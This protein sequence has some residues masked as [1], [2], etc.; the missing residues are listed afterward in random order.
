MNA[1]VTKLTRGLSA[2]LLLLAVVLASAM[3]TAAATVN[4]TLQAKTGS[5]IMPDGAIVPVWGLVEQDNPVFAPIP[6]LTANEGDT[7]IITLQNNLSGPLADEV[8][9][10]INGQPTLDASG[11]TPTAMVPTF[12]PADAYGRQRVHSFTYPA[13]LADSAIYAW[14]PL[15]PGTWLIQSGTHPGVQVPMGLYAILV[16]NS[17]T[18]G[19]AYANVA[20]AFDQEAVVLFS[21]LDPA[22]NGAVADGSYGTEAYPTAMAVG[23]EPHYFLINGQPWSPTKGPLLTVEAGQRVLLRMANT[24]IE[25]REPVLLNVVSMLQLAEDGNPAAL[26]EYMPKRHSIDLVAGKTVD[27]VFIAPANHNTL[28]LHD[29]MLGLKNGGMLDFIAVV[30]PAATPVNLVVNVTGAGHV[31]ST[32]IPGGIDC[33]AGS[34]SA[35]YAPNTAVTLHATGDTV[36]TALTG[37]SVTDT[38]TSTP[39]G[40][41]STLSDCVVTLDVDKTVDA[42]FTTNT[43]LKLITPSGGEQVPIDSAYTVTWTAPATAITFDLAYS[44]GPGLPF[45]KMGD[46]VGGHSFFWTLPYPLHQS[47]AAR[48]AII[49]YDASGTEL[50][51][52]TSGPFTLV[53]PFVLTAPAVGDVLTSKALFDITWTSRTTELPITRGGLFYRPSPTTSWQPIAVLDTTALFAANPA[54]TWTVA[55]V[56]ASISTAEVALVLYDNN[57]AALLIDTSGAFTIDPALAVF[58]YLTPTLIVDAPVAGPEPLLLLIPNGGEVLPATGLTVIW[59]SNLPA[60]SY[61]LELSI[62]QGANW[63]PLAEGLT[64]TQ[65]NWIPAA[66]LL[67]KEGLMLRLSA[68]D[69]DGKV[70]ATDTSDAAFAFGN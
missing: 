16:V 52:D 62:D 4:V 11:S 55:D 61:S 64:D 66:E 28:P 57:G 5:V 24:G 30:D 70:L 32:S 10:V 45:V 59:Q 48:V 56:T 50:Q 20:S 21:E 7:L 43:A 53:S 22:L 29:R 60:A 33:T 58:N 46:R 38:L 44:L 40:E 19:Q 49:S 27:A 65:F 36:D 17:T 34:C 41:C 68:Q 13:P 47:D 54:Y 14:G 51:R 26:D 42:T 12:F 23:Y 2:W 67:G 35:A 69:A 63:S 18:P 31:A 15:K 1:Y 39:T 8:S 6:T 25:S 3:P 37:W 9:L